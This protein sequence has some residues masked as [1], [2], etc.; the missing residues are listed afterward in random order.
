MRS[1]TSL[2]PPNRIIT[3]KSSAIFLWVRG[4][5]GKNQFIGSLNQLPFRGR[6]TAHM[7]V[8]R[9]V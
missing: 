6:T 2:S 9:R 1:Q 3:I 7:F 5:F 8:V 4:T